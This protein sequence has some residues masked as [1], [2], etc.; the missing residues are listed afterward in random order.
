MRIMLLSLAASAALLAG[1]SP[2]NATTVFAD[3]FQTDLS[4]W[5]PAQGFTGTAAIVP[6]PLPGGSGNALTFGQATAHGDIMTATTFGS[7]TGDYTVSFDYLGTCR[8]SNCGLFVYDYVNGLNLVSD[9]SYPNT[10]LQIAST[11]QWEH[12]SVSFSVN[13][14]IGILLE[15][16]IGD[17]FPGQTHGAPPAVTYLRNL[18]VTETPL[19][20]ALPLF[21][22]GVGAMGLLGWRR[23]RKTAAQAAPKHPH[24]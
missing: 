1:G 9:F 8:Y 22:T 19:P 2:G 3:D 18:E 17:Q 21:A 12:V 24:R 20:A 23:T 16:W 10:L 14:P 7:G 4:Q 6:D 13:G 5:V 11:G 15:D